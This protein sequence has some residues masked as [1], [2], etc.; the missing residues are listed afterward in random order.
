MENSQTKTTFCEKCSLLMEFIQQCSPLRDTKP[1]FLHQS[2]LIVY[3]CC[4]K[5]FE[6]NFRQFILTTFKT[7]KAYFVT[8]KCTFDK[9][10]LVKCISLGTLLNLISNEKFDIEEFFDCN[11]DDEDSE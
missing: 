2:M 7:Y 1:S 4:G 5:D 8:D 6:E 9:K 10:G 11:I 3:D